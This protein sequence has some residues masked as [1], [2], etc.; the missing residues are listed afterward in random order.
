MFNFRV[1]RNLNIDNYYPPTSLSGRY[2]MT[3]AEGVD[4]LKAVLGSGFESFGS[5]HRWK[6]IHPNHPNTAWTL[7]LMLRSYLDGPGE[8]YSCS[9]VVLFDSDVN[10]ESSP[11]S[12]LDLL[13]M[14]ALVK[15][16]GNRYA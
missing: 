9:V 16:P 14:D 1:A 12:D 13:L 4:N 11:Y 3:T 6:L 7:T 10:P 5:L 8:P 15:I 2:L